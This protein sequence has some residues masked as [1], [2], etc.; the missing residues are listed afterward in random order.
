MSKDKTTL[1]ERT[2][3]RQYSTSDFRVELQNQRRSDPLKRNFYL[4]LISDFYPDYQEEG[5][6]SFLSGMPYQE[7][8][9]IEIAQISDNLN[10]YTPA[11]DTSE[12][13]EMEPLCSLV[14]DKT[15]K[16]FLIFIL[17]KDEDGRYAVST[18]YIP[19]EYFE[20]NFRNKNPDQC[21]TAI[22]ESYKHGKVVT[23]DKDSKEKL[24]KEILGFT[25]RIVGTNRSKDVRMLLDLEKPKVNI[26]T[27]D[28]H[29]TITKE[30]SVTTIIEN[31][32]PKKIHTVTATFVTNKEGKID[33]D[34]ELYI[35]IRDDD[36]KSHGKIKAKAVIDK[37]GNASF[38]VDLSK[39]YY[40]KNGKFESRDATDEDKKI[41]DN[42]NFRLNIVQR[43]PDN[44]GLKFSTVLKFRDEMVTLEKC[45]GRMKDS[46]EI[47]DVHYAKENKGKRKLDET[48]SPEV[49]YPEG[50]RVKSEELGIVQS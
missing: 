41:T 46:K 10:Y 35:D 21:T 7:F 26:G 29:S 49:H 36:N 39:I 37:D 28:N 24:E 2:R 1:A 19:Q 15:H 20:E 18:Q 23:I 12:K 11:V 40:E 33:G 9:D 45:S 13:S 5:K 34:D 4:S 31:G 16:K 6:V 27:N 17:D 30:R 32:K 50:K 44:R 3:R 14:Y 47:D 48:P 38:D 22:I 8:S 25:D 42:T 43:N